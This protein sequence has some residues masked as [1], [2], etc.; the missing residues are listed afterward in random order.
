M[1]LTLAAG[2]GSANLI[3]F[4]V[5]VMNIKSINATQ[6]NNIIIGCYSLFP[7]AGAVIADSFFSSFYVVSVFAF[8]SLLGLIMLTLAS[9]IHSLRPPT[10][11]IGSLAC[12][13]PSKLQYAVLYLALALASLGVGGTRFTLSAMGADQFNKPNEQ[14]TF[15][16]W[17]FFT[18]YLASAI[19]LTAIIYVQDSVSWGLGFGIGVVANAIGLAVFLLG[20]RF[21]CHT[22][23]KGSPFVGIARVLVAA[24]RKRR[25]L[26]TF[27]SQGYFHG[28][29]TKAISSPT[30]SLRFL[31]CAALR[32]EDDRKSDGSYSSSRWLCTVE[33]VEDLKTLIKIMP[34]W[35]SG[36]LLST[37]IAMTNSLTVLQALTMDRHLGPHFTIP[38]GSFLVFSI[39]ATALSI[40]IIDR[41]LLPMWKNL[42]RRSLKPLQQIGIGHVINIFAMVGS[43]LVETRRLRV[44]RTHHLNGEPPGSVVP[45]S[46][47]W[48]VVPL[49]VIGVGEAFHFPGQVALYYQEFPTSLRSTSTAMISLL[50]AIAYYLSTAIIDSVRRSTGWLPDNIN[51]GRLDYVFWL[52][53]AIAFVNFGYYLLCTKFFKYQNTEN[54]ENEASA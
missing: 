1:G 38:A 16:S 48:L 36:I 25:K 3:V 32:Y 41:F 2:G 27:Q 51:D 4:L 18:L 22:K 13:A 26:E 14:G 44:V 5:T 49:L 9:T 7:V 24:I 37:T 8:V 47:L 10:C 30:E 19:S 46:G 39:L 20:K 34:L 28:D 35:S 23:P 50:I 45:M 52:L 12:E 53:T 17:Y 31:N 33:E 11:V 42:T 43:A 15:F 40:S 54:H 29:N 6:I 21:Y